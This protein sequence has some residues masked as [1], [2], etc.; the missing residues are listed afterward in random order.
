MFLFT[1]SFLRLFRLMMLALLL[2]PL[3][4]HAFNFTI[5]YRVTNQDIHQFLLKSEPLSQSFTLGKV[6]S[7]HYALKDP[8]IQI[9]TTPNHLTAEADLTW[10]MTMVDESIQAKVHFKF[11]AIPY[12]NAETG[13]IYLQAFKLLDSSITPK[14][15]LPQF[16]QILPWLDKGLEKMLSQTPIY[17]LN[18]KK[19][20]QK[21]VKKFTQRIVVEKGYLRFEGKL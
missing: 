11:Q 1:F 13:E 10:T 21:M 4:S 9:G 15:Y 6:L 17:R 14:E 8:V 18:E 2:S 5:P 3:S 20:A 19:F 7:F 12:Y 16:E